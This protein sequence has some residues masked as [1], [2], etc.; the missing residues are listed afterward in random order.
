L[1][2]LNALNTKQ[3]EAVTTLG[4]PVLVF[5]G[6]GSGKTR[7]L[8]YKIAY[9]VTEIGL[10]P[11]NILAVTFTNKAAS[12]MKERVQALLPDIDTSI[13]NVGTFHSISA[14]LLRREIS[15]IGYSPNF[16]IYDQTD[17]RTL[18]KQVI[19]RLNLDLK[20]YDPNGIQT[21]I[22]RLKNNMESPDSFLAASGGYRDEMIANIFREYQEELKK[23]NSVDFDDLLLLP[24][25]I[26]ENF[27][28]RKQFYQNRFQYILVDE[29]QDTNRPQFEFVHALSCEHREICV[30]GD[31]DQSIYGWRGANIRNIL[32]FE[33]SFGESKL[34]KLEQNYRST[35]VI[36]EAA[37]A[38]IAKNKHRK[39]KKLWT[40]NSEGRKITILENYSERHEAKTLVSALKWKDEKEYGLNDHVVLYRTNA[41]SRPLEDEFRKSGIPY[42]IVGGVKFYERKEIKDVLAYLKVLVNPADSISLE[43]IVNFPPRTLGKTTID[44]LKVLAFAE[45]IPLFD[46]LPKA[47][48]A[49]AG[50]RQQKSLAGFYHLINDFRKRMTENS[51]DDL[52]RQLV[53]KIDLQNYYL[54]QTTDEGA[55]R[56]ANILE[57]IASVTE[58]QENYPE[59]DIKEFLE[60]VS[61]LTDIDRWNES[62]QAVTLMTLHSAKGLEFPVVFIAGLEEGLFPLNRI[63]ENDDEMEEER[64]LFYVGVTRAKEKVYLS[65]AHTRRR[66]G[67]EP[68]ESIPSR[69]IGDIPPELLEVKMKKAP[70]PY[71]PDNYNRKIRSPRMTNVKSAA[72]GEIKEGDIVLHKIYGKG[73]VLEVKGSGENARLTIAF[74]GS[75]E[76][77]FIAKYANLRRFSRNS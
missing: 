64:R 33:E 11:E 24:L 18:V 60:E 19:T 29:Y 45:N 66:Y 49:G 36:L 56:W 5:A 21:L 70:R 68:M 14:G 30:V 77:K 34:I 2:D 9:L 28:D 51:A 22:S 25:V 58:Y 47:T 53:E 76:K 54:E 3:R 40:D 44:R 17:S 69:F 65:Y 74:S 75:V 41:Q 72:S 35:K 8:T 46:A 42:V 67:G 52:L 16:T 55:E 6:A 10:P 39:E 43:R 32:D 26:F 50:I 13:M 63:M 71:A 73:R 61:L 20:Q 38:V 37:H 23:N 12:E 7:V 27:P 31:D 59:N 48:A 57:L 15:R 1:I 4:G 62:T